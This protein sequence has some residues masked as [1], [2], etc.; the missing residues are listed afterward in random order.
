MVKA[1]LEDPGRWVGLEIPVVGEVLT[2][3]QVAETYSEV[4]KQPARAVFVDSVEQEN[5]P[6]WIARHKGYKEVGYFPKYVGR[7]EEIP[8]L[9]RTLHPGIKS[10]RQ[11]LR[12]SGFDATRA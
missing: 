9:A 5:I 1:I 2:I 11:W 8:V 10:F 12:E 6:Q 3:P 4:T 7:E